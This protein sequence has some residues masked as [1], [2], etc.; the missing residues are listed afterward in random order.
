MNTKFLILIVLLSQQLLSQNRLK[1]IVLDQQ[2]KEPLEYADIYNSENYTSS[3]ED[4]RFIFISNNDSLNIGLLGYTT[5]HSTF[6]EQNSD[7]ILLHKK[8]QNLEEIVINSNDNLLKS[9]LDNFTNNYPLNPYK[10]RFFLR[11]VLRRN[12]KIIQLVDLSGKVERQTLFSTKSNPMPKKN[13]SVEIENL[14]KAGIKEK[15]I[16]FSLSPFEELFTNFNSIYM[17]P[18][19]Y[20]FKYIPYK[21]SSF[22][23]LEFTPK[24]E[25]SIYSTG[26]YLVN[27][28]DN[29]F[30]EVSITNT[31]DSEFVERKKLKYRTTAYEVLVTFKKDL[32]SKKYAIDK[33]NMKATV[34]VVPDDEEKI[35][36][37]VAYK[38]YTF[39]NFHNFEVN[40]NISL[41]KDIFRLKADYDKEF[42]ESQHYLLLTEEMQSFLKM[43]LNEENN[44]FKNITNF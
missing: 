15:D 5:L 18:E 31:H 2:T 35:V 30:N 20:N 10:E 37:T 22:V 27:L 19:I 4:G 12:N 34:E 33:G 14:R 17:S 11:S 32:E 1:G 9:V 38:L 21:D 42:W 23:R 29:A 6:Q 16:E 28:E 39:D 3:N 43:I 26:Y 25:N 7:T 44:D 41:S 36:Y 8:V 13:Y 40:N 24:K